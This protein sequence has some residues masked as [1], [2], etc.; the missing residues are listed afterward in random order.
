[1][2]RKKKPVYKRVWFWL[3]A[4]VLIFIG[5]GTLGSKNSSSSNHSSTSQADSKINQTNFDKIQLSE[6]DGTSK[7]DV[8]AM[9]GKK[10]MSS[11]S[12]QIQGTSAEDYVWSGGLLGKSVTI[13]FVNGHAVSK[14]IDS[15]EGTKKISSDQFDAIQNGMTKDQVK[16]K[17]GKPSGTSISTIAGQSAE[18]WKYSGKGDL[19]ANLMITF[20]NGVVSGKSQLGLK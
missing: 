4:V 7:D 10:P 5:F 17:L 14:A 2:T 3:L 19:G 11:S 13:G 15:I 16:D 18:D 12:Q 8:V 9:F 1:M 20:S 6:T